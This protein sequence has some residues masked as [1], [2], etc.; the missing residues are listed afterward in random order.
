M[1]VVE[2]TVPAELRWDATAERQFREGLPYHLP[3]ARLASI[4]A[5]LVR[6]ECGETGA[7]AL[8]AGAI[9]LLTTISRDLRDATEIVL[10]ERPA[11]PLSWLADPTEALLREGALRWAGPA[12]FV[13]AGK[14][15]HLMNRL[16]HFL[17]EYA[18]SSGAEPEAYPTTV[19]TRTLMQCGYLRAFPQHAL[20]VAPAALSAESLHAMGVIDFVGKI[21]EAPARL[22]EHSQVLAPTVCYPCFESLNGARMA[23]FRQITA[24]NVCH[25]HE[26]LAND[27]LDR[28]Q[29]FR[30]RE[31]I[32]FGSDVEV[33]GMLD[34]GLEWTSTALSRWGVAHRAVTATDAFFAGASGNKQFFQAAFALKRELQIQV[35][36][37]RWL[38]VASFNHHQKSLT[39]AF[40]IAA[41]ANPLSSGCIGWGYERL[42]FGMFAHFG[43]DLARWPAPLLD[44]LDLPR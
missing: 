9:A 15:A 20:F 18:S 4:E 29:T 32:G 41:V 19:A 34:R 22:A 37:A 33:L 30:M 28:L 40:D 21:G 17:G 7:E 24:V 42:L 12:R 10:F 26:I 23:G 38:A 36:D 35:G 39:R 8:T 44:D 14:F 25:R 5:R 31:L 1:T 2:V 16:D 3:G 11:P 27:K 43:V 13:Y 6:L